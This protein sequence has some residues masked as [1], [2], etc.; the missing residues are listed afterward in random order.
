MIELH[1]EGAREPAE[2]KFPESAYKAA[3]GKPEPTEA[4]WV[5]FEYKITWPT[6]V[7][8]YTFAHEKRT[9]S[10]SRQPRGLLGEAIMIKMVM[11]SRTNG[12][13]LCP[14]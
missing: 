8:N 1:D 12:K 7:V 14:E 9:E 11:A 6:D 4:S 13:K 2:Y 10:Q 3:P 5:R